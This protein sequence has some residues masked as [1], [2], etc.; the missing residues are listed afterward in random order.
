MFIFVKYFSRYYRP[1][2]NDDDDDIETFYGAVQEICLACARFPHSD[3]LS[4]CSTGETYRQL[5]S[6]VMKH[7]QISYKTAHLHETSWFF[8]SKL[9][10]EVLELTRSNSDLEYTYLY[11]RFLVAYMSNVCI[12]NKCSHGRLRYF[13]DEEPI[14]QKWCCRLENKAEN[15]LDAH[16]SFCNMCAEEMVTGLNRNKYRY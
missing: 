5:H 10:Q 3:Y 13:T 11:A 16:K 4:A 7:D 1:V 15:S 9:Y 12:R 2:E 8:D 14:I 6:L